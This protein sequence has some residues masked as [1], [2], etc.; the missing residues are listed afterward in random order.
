MLELAVGDADATPVILGT[1]QVALTAAQEDELSV[2][3]T[4]VTVAE[5]LAVQ[6]NLAFFEALL[7]TGTLNRKK[8]N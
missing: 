3:G 6:P 8:V 4:L 7:I 2:P 5:Q 1:V